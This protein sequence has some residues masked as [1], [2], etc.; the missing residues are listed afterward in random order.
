[1]PL[2]PV[3]TDDTWIM[4]ADRLPE[5]QQAV[6]YFFEVT[7]V[8]AGHYLGIE[9][10]LPGF[11]GERGFLLGDVTHWKPRQD[12]DST[13]AVPTG[14]TYPERCLVHGAQTPYDHLPTCRHGQAIAPPPPATD[15]AHAAARAVF[16]AMQDQHELRLPLRELDDATRR[17]L[18]ERVRQIVLTAQP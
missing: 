10:G 8:S 7:G 14:W 6:W 12:G 13:P 2:L 3:P 5:E 18:V 16:E 15:W 17:R 1:M 11:G 9:E 4:V